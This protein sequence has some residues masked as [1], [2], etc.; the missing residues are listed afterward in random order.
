VNPPEELKAMDRV[1]WLKQ[2][3]DKAEMLYDYGVER[4]GFDTD[5]KAAKSRDESTVQYIQKFLGYMTPQSNLLSAGCGTGRYDGVLLKAV[6]SVVGTDFSEGSLEQARELYPMIRYK[7]I[8]H[9]KLNFRNEFDGAICID[10]LEHVFPEEWPVILHRFREALKPGG[11]L[12]FTVYVSVSTR[13]LERSYEQARAQGLP[14]VR[15]E[16]VDDE[17]FEKVMATETEELE[18]LPGELLDRAVYHYYPSL[19]KI[20][21]WL[22]QERFEIETEG[23]AAYYHFIVRKR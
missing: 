22:E 9:H 16:V 21:K 3:R 14:V 1:E 19:E 12:Y 7:K 10:A 17:A 5:E 8:A 11:M 23:P 13:F 15:G 20:R 4:W 18:N 2:M 6:H